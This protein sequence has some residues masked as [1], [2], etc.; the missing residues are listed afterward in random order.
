[1]RSPRLG[2]WLRDRA[3]PLLTTSSMVY[4]MMMVSFIK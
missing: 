1:M 2:F 4:L 3:P